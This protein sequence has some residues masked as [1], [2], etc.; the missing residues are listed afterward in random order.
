[1]VLH[2][3]FIHTLQYICNSLHKNSVTF[4]IYNPFTIRFNKSILDQNM[5]NLLFMCCHLRNI[6]TTRFLKKIASFHHSKINEFQI[7]FSL[8][9][10]KKVTKSNITSFIVPF[11]LERKVKACIVLNRLSLPLVF[12]GTIVYFIEGRSASRHK[13]SF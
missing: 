11:A 3:I 10:K 2:L 8:F 4:M 5:E 13:R 12:L 9:L 6:C 7:P 1:M